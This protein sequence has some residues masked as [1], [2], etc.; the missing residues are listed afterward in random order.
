MKMDEQFSKHVDEIMQE[1]E[2][3]LRTFWSRVVYACHHKQHCDMLQ[4]IYDR[5][6]NSNFKLMF[7]I[8]IFIHICFSLTQR[9]GEI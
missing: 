2:I 6:S 4:Q 9:E 5:H 1:S 8:K 3:E 7:T